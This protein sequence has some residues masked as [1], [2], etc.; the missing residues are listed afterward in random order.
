[1][2]FILKGL[3]EGLVGASSVK[4]SSVDELFKEH[5]C[6][7]EVRYKLSIE[8]NVISGFASCDG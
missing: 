2:S 3:P 6:L 4:A 5:S 8:G 1:M 7:E